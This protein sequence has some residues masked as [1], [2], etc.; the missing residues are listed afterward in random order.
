MKSGII[1]SFLLTTLI[2]LTFSGFSHAQ[3]EWDVQRTFNLEEPALD[4]AISLN[5]RWVYVLTDQGEIHI[6]SHEGTL[7]G[8]ISV[9]ESVDRIKPGPAQDV[10]FIG[11]RKNKTLQ[12]ITLDFIQDINTKGSPFKGPADAP[13]VIAVSA[14]FKRL[15]AP[16]SCRYSN[17]CSQIIRNR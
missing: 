4:V 17:R 12:I 3:V 1:S 9:G 2:V 16:S 11:S 8:E 15:P 6:Y 14:I 5:G 7:K 10:L 13:V